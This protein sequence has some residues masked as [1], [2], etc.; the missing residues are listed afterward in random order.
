MPELIIETGLV[1]GPVG[2]GSLDW[3]PACGAEAIFVGRTRAEAHP[4][5]G[6]LERLEYEVYE[7]MAQALLDRAARET[8]AR[9]G[10]EAV[11]VVHSRGAV[12]PGEASVVIEV[13]T[14]HRSEAF[15]ACREL[16]DRI[17]HE[18]PVWKTQVWQRGR[19]RVKG[20][21]AHHPSDRTLI[22]AREDR[23]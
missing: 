2:L 3:P 13:A 11:R 16:I 9:H 21:C 20:C 5:L 14:G 18:L 12:A 22:E 17:K 23:A 7:P 6:A 4:E 1:D 19:T 15:I 10:A 8:A